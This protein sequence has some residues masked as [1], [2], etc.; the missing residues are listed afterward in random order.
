MESR[1]CQL[2]LS[3]LRR[4]ILLTF[5]ATKYKVLCCSAETTSDDKMALL[6]TL[7]CSDGVASVDFEQLD[8]SACEVN[9]HMAAISSDSNT[10]QDRGKG[11][12]VL[13]FVGVKV[14][15]IEV[16]VG[17]NYH[18]SLAI[19]TDGTILCAK[20]AANSVQI[21]PSQTPVAYRRCLLQS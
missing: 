5:A 15:D 17:V 12:T 8:L 21:C 16:S 9:E 13:L 18:Q 11:L 7:E 20:S 19:R 1:I 10:S 6:L 14:E 3:I 2:Q 4:P